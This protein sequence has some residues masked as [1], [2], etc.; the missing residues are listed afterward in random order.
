MSRVPEPGRIPDNTKVT[1][2]IIG[3]NCNGVV[4]TSE[5]TRRVTYGSAVKDLLY[6]VEFEVPLCNCTIYGCSWM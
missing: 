5:A 4:Y 2:Y 3:V 1:A 6:D